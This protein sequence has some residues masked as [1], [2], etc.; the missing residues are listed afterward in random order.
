MI[1]RDHR[2]ITGKYR[3]LAHRDCIINV[4]VN[5][6]IPVVFHNLKTYGSHLIMQKLGKFNI[7]TN[8]IPNR[9]GKYMSFTI[10]NKLRFIDCFQFLSF[11]LENLVKILGKDGFKYLSQEFGNKILDILKQKGFHFYKYICDFEKF[12]EKLGR[13]LG[14][15][16]TRFSP[17]NFYKRRD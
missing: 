12:K 6:K 17:V 2:H 11:S 13:R 8:V 9:S 4:K 10:S 1:V 16:S 14:A 3:G 7:K 15:P 5:P